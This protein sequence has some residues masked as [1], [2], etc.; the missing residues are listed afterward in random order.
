MSAVVAGSEKEREFAARQGQRH[1]R[2][3]EILILDMTF[4]NVN[5]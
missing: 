5:Y 4:F 1:S 2:L 3:T